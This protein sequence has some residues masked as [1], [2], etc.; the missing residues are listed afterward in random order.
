M[1]QPDPARVPS[2]D[3]P[4]DANKT[5][6]MP[7][8][9]DVIGAPAAGAAAP[10]VGAAAP[11]GPASDFDEDVE[12][13]LALQ[14]LMRHRKKRRRKKIIAA[15]VAGGIVAAVGIGVAVASS[16]ANQDAGDTTLSTIPVY[17]S[18]FSESVSA[19]GTAEALTSVAVT[20]EIDGIIET[21]S[22]A[23]GDYVEEGQELFTIKND[24]LDKDVR[25]AEI[26]VKSAKAD[27]SSAQTSYNDTYTNYTNQINNPDYYE[28]PG[29][30]SSGG[31][32]TGAND[33]SG[34]G[35]ATGSGTGAAL[36][37]AAYVVRSSSRSA[38]KRADYG[39]GLTG[40]YTGTTWSDVERAQA[41]VESAQLALETAQET[42][43]TA[44]ATAAKRTVTAPQA[45]RIVSCKAVVGES[46][47]SATGGTGSASG[48]LVTI[49]DLSQM[50][51]KVQ[52]NEVDISKIAVDQEAAVTF[53]ALSGAEFTGTV[54]RIST[55]SSSDE[56]SGYSYGVVTY[57][58]EVLI[59]E[60]TDELKPG[61]T[62]SVEIRQ[63]YVP[64]ALTVPVSALATDDGVSYYVLVM[65]DEETQAC[66][67]REV[68]LGAQSDTLAVVE[69]GLN[70]GDLVVL[71]PYAV[72][73]YAEGA[74]SGAAASNAV[75]GDGAAATGDATTDA[76]ATTEADGVTEFSDEDAAAAEVVSSEGDVPA[77][78]AD[79]VETY[80]TDAAA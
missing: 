36:Q 4:A 18:D 54:T 79:S 72:A 30:S 45:G 55:V 49:A 9:L 61:M 60:P 73:E 69:S 62:A 2:P 20:P 57:D 51:V 52:V 21:V 35:T 8:A 38:F 44:V 42:Y 24:Q 77:S 17:V 63:S 58:V 53:S 68:T 16:L 29:S 75:D 27:L 1:T 31:A 6:L 26:G 3:S 67:R 19:T 76:L 65:I 78:E 71:D 7:Q 37:G 11:G 15:C 59:P 50:K 47:G 25:T 28:V 64:N 33:A 56:S 34:S 22:V 39:S 66:E 43:D 23:E 74:A 10:A 12:A 46:I 14:S 13:Q 48:S 80:S 5:H 70:E 40:T 32:T 41:A